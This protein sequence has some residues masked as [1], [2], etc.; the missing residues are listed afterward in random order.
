MSDL[1]LKASKRQVLGKQVRGLRRS[2]IVP[3][4]LYG[5]GVDSLAIQVDAAA[6]DK[7]LSRAGMSHLVSLVIDG[8]KEPHNV[9]FK[10]VQ[11]DYLDDKVIHLDLLQVSMTQKIKV[12]VRIVLTGESP[13]I[14]GK[15]G[16]LMQN[17]WS[18]EIECLPSNIPP[19]FEVDISVLVNLDDAIHVKD[20]KAPEGM[21]I[22]SDPTSMVVKVGTV[23]VVKEEV[24]K[25]A[26]AVA[27][28]GAEAAAAEG[29]EGAAA[30]GEAKAEGGKAEAKGE[31]KSEGKRPAGKEK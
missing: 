31:A 8:D 20:L 21:A 13:A 16:T 5:K 11:R 30:E 29:A 26:E 17:M 3:A 22:A 6:L 7:V 25:P 10:E 15:L 1:E 27:A 19:S 12:P 24:V 4:H 2:G 28:E 9:L 23:R 18:L 14:K